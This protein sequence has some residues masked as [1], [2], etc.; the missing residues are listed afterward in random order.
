MTNLSWQQAIIK[1]LDQAQFA[2]EAGKEGMA[3]V[4]ARRA[5]GIAIGKYLEENNF[6]DPGP[7]VMDRLQSLCAIPHIADRTKRSA[8]LLSLRV[9]TYHQLPIDADLIEEAQSLIA[10]L[11]PEFPYTKVKS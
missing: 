2:R 10:S 8:N 3:R 7:S 6:P 1:E 4:C 5:A 9:D 11:F